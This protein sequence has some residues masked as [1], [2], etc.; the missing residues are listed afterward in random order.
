MLLTILSTL[1][2]SKGLAQRKLYVKLAIFLF[3][4]VPAL[5]TIVHNQVATKTVVEKFSFSKL[6]IKKVIFLL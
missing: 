4:P 3:S 1:T 5:N 2:A 6:K